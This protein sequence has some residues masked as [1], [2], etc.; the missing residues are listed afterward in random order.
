MVGR[1]QKKTT[2]KCG[3]GARVDRGMHAAL[4]NPLKAR[5]IAHRTRGQT[6]GPITRLV[7][8]SDLGEIIKPFVFLDLFTIPAGGEPLF[9][10]HPHSGIATL[11]VIHEGA[12]TYEETTGQKGLL[13]AGSIEWMRAGRGVWHTGTTVGPVTTKG[14]QLWIALPEQLEL[15]PSQSRYLSAEDVPTAGNARVILGSYAEAT[16]VIA[17]PSGINYFDVQLKAG[18]RWSYR[19]PAGHQVAWLAVSQGVVRVGE[20]VSAGEMV[21]FEES[22]ADLAIRAESAARLVLG[23]AIKHRHPLVLGRHSVHTTAEALRAGKREIVRI[24]SELA[25]AGTIREF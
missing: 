14:F 6:H 7:S 10:W 19:P 4:Q 25:A 15:A 11:T 8:P 2:I 24:G 9:G 5:A 3:Q 20:S 23:S 17:A 16:S 21:I 22:S 1:V 18:E 12:T 13:S